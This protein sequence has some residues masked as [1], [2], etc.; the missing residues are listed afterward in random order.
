MRPSYHTV[1]FLRYIIV[2]KCTWRTYSTVITT[3]FLRFLTRGSAQNESEWHQNKKSHQQQRQRRRSNDND[4]NDQTTARRCLILLESSMRFY[5]P[6]GLLLLCALTSF[7]SKDE[8]SKGAPPAFFLIDS[9]DQLCLAGE[10][11]KRCS[12]DTLFYV[13]GSPGE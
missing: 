7:A 6:T 13:V 12:I 8:D 2:S 9:T 1:Y 5:Q 11:F 3:V 4:E 10:E